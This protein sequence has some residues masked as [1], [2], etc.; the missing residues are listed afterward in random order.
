[1]LFYAT[2]DDRAAAAIGRLITVSGFDPVRA[3]DVSEA[4]RLEVPGGDLHQNGG[5]GGKLLDADQ[6]HAAVAAA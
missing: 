2:N 1:V 5:L 6:A 4:V 3:G